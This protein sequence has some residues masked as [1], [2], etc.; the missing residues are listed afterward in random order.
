MM[1][2]KAV[3][4]RLFWYV[5]LKKQTVYQLWKKI[6]NYHSSKIVVVVVTFKHSETIH[7]TCVLAIILFFNSAPT[8]HSSQKLFFTTYWQQAPSVQ[9]VYIPYNCMKSLYFLPSVICLFLVESLKLHFFFLP[10]CKYTVH[11]RC[12]ARAPPS[13]IKTYV[14]S[15]KNTEVRPIGV[16][17]SQHDWISD[18]PQG[19]GWGLLVF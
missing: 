10:V 1:V 7:L 9:L 19:L 14:K 16:F 8:L 15:K 4:K 11:E 18:A 13:C 12:V 2:L 17:T 3:L 5:M 6:T